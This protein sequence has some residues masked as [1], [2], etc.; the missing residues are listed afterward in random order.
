MN[1]AIEITMSRFIE[2]I[3]KKLAALVLFA[4]DIGVADARQVLKDFSGAG[5]RNLHSM[6]EAYDPYGDTFEE[7]KKEVLKAILQPYMCLGTP[8]VGKTERLG[9]LANEATALLRALG[10]KETFGFKAIQLGKE[11]VGS[12]SGIPVVVN[13]EIEERLTSKLPRED[14]D[15]KFG[16]L[17]LDEITSVPLDQ[18]QPATSLLDS[19]RGIPPLYELPPYWLVICSGNTSEDRNYVDLQDNIIQ[20]TLCFHVCADTQDWLAYAKKMKFP[21]SLRAFLATHPGKEVFNF[22]PTEADDD[23]GHL[24]TSPRTWAALCRD[25]KFYRVDRME[26]G[27]DKPDIEDHLAD[28]RE[29]ACSAIG[30][31]LGVSLVTF[32]ENMKK[33][34]VTAVDILEKGRQCPHVGKAFNTETMMGLALDARDLLLKRI[35]SSDF[36]A[37]QKC[38]YMWNVLD[39]AMAIAEDAT[40]INYGC[41]MFFALSDRS[42]LAVS[43]VFT[44][45][46]KDS[47]HNKI[48]MN[49]ANKYKAALESEEFL[50]TFKPIFKV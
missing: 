10:S 47:A 9:A 33:T 39:W 41:A 3:R 14:R 49:F 35:N 8:G 20:R 43:T 34:G 21:A 1:N 16:I 22:S 18:V 42:N 38:A 37:D 4:D 17:L 24:G 25:M 31:D 2:L 48:I 28:F 12:F 32:V 40:F 50:T 11:L 19:S 26:S 5:N 7:Q 44:A 46:I 36:N 23:T 45:T 27:D 6:I 13:G 15:G 30:Q 29:L